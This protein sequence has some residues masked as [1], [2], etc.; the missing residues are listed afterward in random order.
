MVKAHSDANNYTTP[1]YVRDCEQN[2]DIDDKMSNID[3][4]A[5]HL[6]DINEDQLMFLNITAQVKEIF[7]L[8]LSL[9]YPSIR[10]MS[11]S[12]AFEIAWALISLKMRLVGIKV[13]SWDVIKLSGE[14]QKISF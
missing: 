6:N 5:P 12:L 8:M 9:F 4:S 11:L 3:C 10:K 14:A 13:L 1:A 7:L 2:L